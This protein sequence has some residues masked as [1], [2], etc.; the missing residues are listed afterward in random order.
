MNAHVVTVNPVHIPHHHLTFFSEKVAA[1]RKNSAWVV[2]PMAQSMAA[3][4][5]WLQNV[6]LAALPWWAEKV[7]LVQLAAL[8]W[9][10]G[11]HWKKMYTTLAHLV[12]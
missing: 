4:E 3:A 2:H 12:W 7:Q 10:A 1:C 8:P 9:S 11:T 6:L 5:T